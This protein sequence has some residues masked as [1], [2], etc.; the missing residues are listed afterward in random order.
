MKKILTLV[1]VLMVFLLASCEKNV[2]TFN[3]TDIDLTKSAEVRLVYDLPL[4]ASTTLNITRLAYNDKLVSEVSTALGGIYPNSAAKYH[5]VPAGTVKVDT[6]TGT[7]KDVPHFSKTFDVT[8]GKKHTAFLYDL[9]QPPYVIQ[10]EDVFPASDPWA[11][12]LCYIKFV[13]LLYKADGV[14]PYGTLYLKGRRGAGT[15]ASPY[16]YI[17]LASCGFKESSALI[18]YKLLK[19]TA[20]VW[21][22]TESG[23]AFVVYDAAGNLLQYYPSSSGALTN[24]AA[25][26]F[27]LAKGRGWIFHMNGKVGATYATQAI[28]LSTIALN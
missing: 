3:S 21:S 1:S 5:V 13:N 8:A 9:T 7:T 20:T 24:W 14:T 19:G 6:Y 11:D 17:N 2:I 18:P 25:T 23:L 15:T 10:D 22:G 16:V 4:V 12:T 26:G 28:R 27:S